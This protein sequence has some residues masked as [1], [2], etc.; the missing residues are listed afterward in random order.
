MSDVSRRHLIGAGAAG[1]AVASSGIV[2]AAQERSTSMDIERL[3]ITRA[4]ARLGPVT[5]TEGAVAKG[6]VPVI[7]LVS[8]HKDIVHLCGVTADPGHPGDVKDQT[9]QVLDRIDQLLLLSGTSK[10]KLLTAQVWLAD[11]GHFA[12][13]N[14]VWNGWVDADNPPARCCIEARLWRPELLVEIMVTAAR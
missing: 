13:H 3:G 9:R 12:D 4:G 7:S 6:D 14:R 11:M 1:A 5:I 10:S 8:V 2:Y